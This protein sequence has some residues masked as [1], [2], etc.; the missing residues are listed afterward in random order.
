MNEDAAGWHIPH[1]HRARLQGI[2]YEALHSTEFAYNSLKNKDALHIN[3]V[4]QNKDTYYAVLYIRTTW[5]VCIVHGRAGPH[6][7]TLS[8]RLERDELL[9]RWLAAYVKRA[10]AAQHA[11]LSTK[12]GACT[13]PKPPVSNLKQLTA[14]GY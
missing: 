13:W 6:L 5:C 8:Q 2:A 12:V 10:A 1:A 11:N 7:L 4:L 14:G 3:K 9:W